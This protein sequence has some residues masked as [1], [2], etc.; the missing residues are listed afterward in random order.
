MILTN[1][2]LIV[3]TNHH[4]RFACPLQSS[5]IQIPFG[6]LGPINSPTLVAGLKMAASNSFTIVPGSKLPR[7]PPVFPEGQVEY[8]RASAAKVAS[9]VASFCWTCSASFLVLTKICRAVALTASGG[10]LYSSLANALDKPS[11]N[12]MCSDDDDDDVVGGGED[13]RMGEKASVTRH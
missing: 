12:P 9:P 6:L 4:L 11:N 1:I 2:I 3:N 10:A 7:D 13:G 8:S 5:G